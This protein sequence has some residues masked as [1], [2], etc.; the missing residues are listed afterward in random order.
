M[1]LH[2]VDPDDAAAVAASV[3]IFTAARRVDDPD[4]PP[5]STAVEALRLRYGW[6]LEP[7]QQYVLL[8]DDQPLDG[9][10]LGVEDLNAAV[11]VIEAAVPLRDNRQLVEAEFIIHPDH[12]RRGHGAVALLAFENWVVDRGRNLIWLYPAAD[13]PIACGFVERHGYTLASQDVRRI[14]RLTT[15]LSDRLERLELLARPLATEYRFER[16]RP[17]VTESVLRQLVDVTAA[18]NDAPM[19]DLDV[20]DLAYDLERLQDVEMAASHCGARLYRV[21][22]R[23]ISDGEIGGH[24]LMLIQPRQSAY[25]VQ[26]DT[27]VSRDHRGHRLGLLLKIEMLR[28]LAEA[29]PQLEQIETWNNVDNRLMI[30]V[31][32]ALGY[33]RPRA[34]SVYQRRLAEQ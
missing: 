19:G 29:E 13:D 24:T 28:W 34:F 9:G 22:A 12:R 18:I 32:T 33:E 15:A 6:D 31:N 10:A 5:R 4:D 11:G 17:P 26:D 23:R 21:V 14:Q 20:E 27:A 30:D 16:L 25:G 1:R 2:R 3:E 8:P 7:V